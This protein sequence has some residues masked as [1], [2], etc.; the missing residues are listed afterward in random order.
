MGTVLGRTSRSEIIVILIAFVGYVVILPGILTAACS[1]P[2]SSDTW[3]NKFWCAVNA[4]D[5]LVGLFTL[6]LAFATYFLWRETER[7]AVGAGDQTTKMERSIAE[8][9][10]AA[11]AMEN[12]AYAMSNNAA[13]AA[14]GI[15]N[16]R[17]FAQRQLRAYISVVVGAAVYQE[18]DK[19]LRFEGRPLVVNDGMTPAYKVRHAIKAAIVGVPIPDN[20]DFSVT[21]KDYRGGTAIGPRQNREVGAVVD[22]YIPDTDVAGVKNLS[23]GKCLFVWGRVEYEDAF[24]KPHF[25]QCGQI[26][27]WRADDSVFGVYE[28]RHNDSD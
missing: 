17:E 19:K 2:V 16:Q 20:F 14:S 11:S 12:V 18:R 8:S 10:R 26:L 21:E 9:A 7:L 27:T 25:A 23:S 4:S 24:G 15:A 3:A 28:P 13:S 22:E 6:F 5:W 1:V